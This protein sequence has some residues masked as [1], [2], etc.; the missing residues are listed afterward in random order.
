MSRPSTTRARNSPLSF[1]QSR[2]WLLNQ[3]SGPDPQYN[4]PIV[5]RPRGGI[6]A[7][8]LQ[9]ALHDVVSR[10]E[11]L[12]TLYQV[13]DGDVVQIVRQPEDIQ[14][15]LSVEN[16]SEPLREARVAE[17]ST[18]TF[19]LDTETPLRAWLLSSDSAD[20]VVVVVAHHI[21][22][23]GSSLVPLLRDLGTA[24]AARRDLAEPRWDSLPLQYGDFAVWQR[25]YLGD[26]ADPDSLS[27]RQLAYWRATLAQLP[28]EIEL[29]VD[30]PRPAVADFSG[31]NIVIPISAELHRR[32]VEVARAERMA[33]FTVFH[34]AIAAFLGRSGAGS[35]IPLGGFVNGRT[36]A[37]LDDLVGFFVNTLVFR[38]DIAGDPTF[39]ELLRRAAKAEI[40]AYSHQDLPF[41]MI[42]RDLKLARSSTRHPLVQTAISYEDADLATLRIP[43]LN[44]EVEIGEH[45]RAKFDV[46]VRYLARRDA[47][48]EPAA[49]A[50]NWRYAT[51]LFD[52]STIEPMAG[53]L[54]AFLGSALAD[55]DRCVAEIPADVQVCAVPEPS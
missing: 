6:D 44:A 13:I 45:G 39:R 28:M 17:V 31:G 4:V 15:L 41:D 23:D 40:D 21:A 14:G 29:P 24:Y 22:V 38:V 48:G 1:A 10:H 16:H 12:R 36:D 42:V 50:M 55:I 52:A 27:G 35:D 2:I 49:S 18:Y 46:Y 9:A 20:D 26:S 30:R 37:A 5:V 11:I 54:V 19:S 32:V 51:A 47:A 8:A 25:G 7:D 43:G 3:I 53:G 34:A 33:P